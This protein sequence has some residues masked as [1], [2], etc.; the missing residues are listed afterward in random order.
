MLEAKT[1][2]RARTS[3]CGMRDAA[4]A[5]AALAAVAG[6]TGRRSAAAYLLVHYIMLPN[7]R[8]VVCGGIGNPAIRLA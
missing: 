7:E 6:R 8:S 4:Q 2:S 1:P 5:E 3:H